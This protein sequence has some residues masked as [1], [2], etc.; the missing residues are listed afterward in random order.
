MDTSGSTSPYFVRE[1]HLAVTLARH[2]EPTLVGSKVRVELLRFSDDAVIV[3]DRHERVD[4]TTLVDRIV[5]IALAVAFF[6]R[7]T[8]FQESIEFT[9]R[10][11]QL[12]NALELA[13]RDW[14]SS[15]SSSS[16]SLPLLP[17]H[18]IA[19][20]LVVVSDGNGA[21]RWHTL[22]ETAA[23]L[24]RANVHVFIGT[25]LADVNLTEASDVCSCAFDATF[26]PTAHA[27]RRILA[28]ANHQSRSHFRRIAR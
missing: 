16:S 3:A 17:S 14:S 28:T 24:R 5:R 12:A 21:D 22:R 7:S 1:R 13:A 15:S 4:A 19:R 6:C 10:R 20:V 23:R 8:R 18:D 11:T 26:T 2:L 27:S 25:T 9:G